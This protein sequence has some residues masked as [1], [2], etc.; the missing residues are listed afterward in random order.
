M[1]FASSWKRW[2]KMSGTYSATLSMPS[3]SLSEPSNTSAAPMA[4]IVVAADEAADE[5]ATSGGGAG[6]GR[7]PPPPTGPRGGCALLAARSAAACAGTSS[8]GGGCLPPLLPSLAATTFV[9]SLRAPPCREA[10][11]CKRVALTAEPSHFPRALALEALTLPPPPPPMAGTRFSAPV[12]AEALVGLGPRMAPLERPGDRGV[13]SLLLAS[14]KLV[15]AR[16]YATAAVS[17]TR[18]PL[19]GMAAQGQ[20]TKRRRAAMRP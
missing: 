8:S 18:S 14:R 12:C 10:V 6:G 5:P 2:L 17:C 7:G 11:R 4:G 20:D 9:T 3:S 1:K 19:H 15:G 13:G 16:V